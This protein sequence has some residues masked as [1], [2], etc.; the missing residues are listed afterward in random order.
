M[1]DFQYKDIPD[2]FVWL[3]LNQ[4]KKFCLEDNCVNMD[5][6]TVISCINYSDFTLKNS[7]YWGFS[8]SVGEFFDWYQIDENE[9]R[10]LLSRLSILKSEHSINVEKIP[11]SQINK[12][13]LS[14]GKLSHEEALYFDVIGVNIS[15]RGR[16]IK[17]WDQPL[18]APCTVGENVLFIKKKADS[19]LCLVQFKLECGNKDTIEIAPTIQT[20]SQNEKA[21]G[22]KKL[23]KIY[24][25][26]C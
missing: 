10:Y 17:N 21:D 5:L 13:K 9:T 7:E 12:W 16:E 25:K 11:L 20:S 1:E 19:I 15:V 6:R 22:E 24:E 23:Y 14:S 4:I 26:K 2:N 8:K 18:V 3:T